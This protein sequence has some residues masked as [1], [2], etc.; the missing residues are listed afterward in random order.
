MLIIIIPLALVTRTQHSMQIL[1]MIMEEASFL[2]I[3]PQTRVA[4]LQCT[5]KMKEAN[6]LLLYITVVASVQTMVIDR[7]GGPQKETGKI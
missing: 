6:A 3:L 1:R 7:G 5:K 2:F 4:F